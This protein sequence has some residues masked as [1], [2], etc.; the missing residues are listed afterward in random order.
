MNI[1]SLLTLF[2]TCTLAHSQPAE[3]SREA[4]LQWF[5]EARFGMFI[6]WGVY[7]V[8]AGEWQGKPVGG[9]GEW[10][11]RNGKI[12]VSDY[13]A[14]TPQFTAAKYDPKAW[15]ELAKT[16]GMKYVVITSKHH[17]G[18]ALYDSDVSDWDVMNSGAKRDLLTPLAK[19][20]RAK[21]LKFGL[22]YSQAQ[23][24]THPGGA[25]PDKTNW[26]P[27]QQGDFDQ[28]LKTIALPQVEEIVT[29]FKPAIL[30][31]DTPIEMTPERAKPFADLMAQ[32]PAIV[33]N[34]RLGGGSKGDTKTPE[35]HIPPR[36]YPGERFEVCMTMNDTW[37]FKKNDQ[38]WKS[39]RQILYNLSDIS[40]KGGNFLLNVGPTAEGEIPP[41]S[42]E[43]LKGV[44][45]W[46]KINSDAI[47]GTTASPFPRRLPWGRVTQKTSASRT[48]LFVHVWEWPSD[49]QLLL[50]TVKEVPAKAKLLANG[51][52][53][54]AKK[55]PEGLLL[56]LPKAAPDADVSM[57]RLDFQGPLTVTMDPYIK[58]D[59]SGRVS[60]SA[61]DADAHGWYD[62]N[63]QLRDPGANAYLTD[64]KNSRW[65]VEYH[66]QA[67]EARKWLVTAE[68]A[69]PTPL[70]L[71]LEANKVSKPIKVAAT[72]PELSWKTVPLG[73]IDLPAGQTHFKLKAIPGGWRGISV[74]NVWLDA[75][76]SETPDP[77]SLRA[78]EQ[79]ALKLSAEDGELTGQLQLESG[80]LGYWSNPDDKVTWHAAGLNSGTYEVSLDYA[81]LNDSAGSE[82]EVK[83]GSQVITGKV[84]G[85]GT[86]KDFETLKLGSVLL[87]NAATLTVT[88]KATK[89]P[90][91]AVMNLRAI[92]LT[93]VGAAR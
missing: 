54:R 93:P 79:G 53:I 58:P 85:T 45:R 11:M 25:K 64:W 89:K 41:Q 32:H 62:G 59:A 7:A 44:G 51:K 16:A 33:N 57:L 21:G 27:A 87:E 69:S 9:I 12:P 56:Q 72:G 81:C 86:W 76:T 23:D 63:I 55:T 52:R 67:P 75:V 39:L 34:N 42:I 8:P 38:N 77:S 91:L 6:H 10:I 1:K 15:A 17:D 26:D 29:Q 40:S 66:F 90:G 31:W 82:F 47:Y 84:R 37:G 74:R 30:W 48:T 5:D 43:L 20:V 61:Q 2:L 88:V 78:N 28:Y 73:I 46:M 80:Y 68:V 22:Y 71:S 4:Q 13:K 65:H 35:Q 19:A 83:I 24:W 50:P 70:R 14:F 36:G 92:T 60:F 3:P 18:F 49:G